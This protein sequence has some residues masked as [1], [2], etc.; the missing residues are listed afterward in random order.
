MLFLTFTLHLKLKSLTLISVDMFDQLTISIASGVCCKFRF[1]NSVF[2]V[3]QS[4][5][6]N[7]IIVDFDQQLSN[8]ST[9][10]FQIFH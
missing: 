7:H 10:L 2:F 1:H 9:N 8:V 6:I 3:R 5:K 4:V